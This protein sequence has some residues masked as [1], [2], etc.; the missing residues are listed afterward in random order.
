MRLLQA[1]ES[2]T[3]LGSNGTSTAESRQRNVMGFEHR[4]AKS[5]KTKTVV[6]GEQCNPDQREA[7]LR[8]VYVRKK[9]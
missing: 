4:L 7:T 5:F 2:Q 8:W 3:D 9:A 1:F 6:P